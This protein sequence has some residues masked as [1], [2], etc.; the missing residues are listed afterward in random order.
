MFDLM[1]LQDFHDLCTASIGTTV[2][3]L[4]MPH[5]WSPNG[6]A[7]AVHQ[8]E[9]GPTIVETPVKPE[10]ISFEA[11]KPEIVQAA[12]WA[13]RMMN[14]SAALNDT[15]MGNPAKGMPASAQALQRAQA[16]QYHQGPQDEYVRLL[17]RTANGR[18][19]LLKR[20]ARTER[21]SEIAGAAGGW[22][23]AKWKADD[24][25]GVERF[26][27]EPID[28]ATSTR[29]G[30]QA[31]AEQ[32]GVTGDA[33][34]DF[35]TTGNL[36]KSTEART[37]QLE[38]VERNKAL[39]LRGIGLGPVDMAASQQAGQ[40]IF[41]ATPGQEVVSILRSDPHHLG[42]PAY[43][44]VVNSPTSR[45]DAKLTTAALDCVQ[46]SLRLWMTLTPDECAAF[47]VPPLPST[48]QVAM[49]PP[50]AGPSMAANVPTAPAGSGPKVPEPPPN[51]ITGEEQRPP[52][53]LPAGTT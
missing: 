12:E 5:L 17:E 32:L 3:L 49:P 46:E 35:M 19:R 9:T 40:P 38:L 15:V 28:P 42:I 11:L 41:V 26:Q 20:F 13:Q 50:G 1:G 18:L 36:R 33:L 31:L 27:M 39:L 23:I 37:L 10:L 4:G 48:M 45:G 43:L 47:G 24:I 2:N 34:F 7:P 21:V 16:V 22:E 44:S 14:L 51:P 30:R 6:A 25:A 8:M 52:L 53:N 29:E